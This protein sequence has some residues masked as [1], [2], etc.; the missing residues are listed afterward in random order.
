[1]NYERLIAEH[2]RIDLAVGDMLGLVGEATPDVD[3]VVLK[4]SDLAGEL[5]EHLAHEDSFIYPAMIAARDTLI[6]DTA[7]NFVAEFAALRHDWGLYLSEWSAETIQTDWETFRTETRSMMNR[8][9]ARVSAENE[10]LYPAALQHG[11]ISLRSS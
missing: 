11:V 10:L 1:M 6:S 7:K 3:A 4:L 5:R 9:A 2:A 8:L